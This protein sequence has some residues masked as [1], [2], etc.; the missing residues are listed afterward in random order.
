LKNQ[1]EAGV[2]VP[3]GNEQVSFPFIGALELNITSMMNILP[4]QIKRISG[5]ILDEVTQR[6]K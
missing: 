4:Y 3:F 1:D 2:Q 6:L 5:R